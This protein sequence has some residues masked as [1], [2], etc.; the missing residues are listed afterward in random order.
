MLEK[1]DNPID[2]IKIYRLLTRRV[3]EA[4]I[5]AFFI[6]KRCEF[7]YQERLKSE[8]FQCEI[9]TYILPFM[10]ASVAT[11]LTIF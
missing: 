11:L 7:T 1:R 3:F 10:K 2:F 5:I 8:I 9:V 6:E 4:K